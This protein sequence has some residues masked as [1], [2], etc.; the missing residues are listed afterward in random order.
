MKAKS[1]FN[2]KPPRLSHIDGLTHFVECVT[3]AMT[4]S[5]DVDYI[6]TLK[7]RLAIEASNGEVEKVAM[8]SVRIFKVLSPA[9]AG[10]HQTSN[11]K[12]QLVWNC[13]KYDPSVGHFVG[14][15][16][17]M[18]PENSGAFL[19]LVFTSKQANL[20]YYTGYVCDIFG[21]RTE[22]FGGDENL[23]LP[24]DNDIDLSH[25]PVDKFHLFIDSDAK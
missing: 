2:G 21:R 17:W 13:F 23:R 7:R 12:N 25:V 14:S 24:R 1:I 8:T 11:S 15:L 4:T 3:K 18:A 9:S 20:Y 10:L 5:E 22:R 19:T 6:E 16:K